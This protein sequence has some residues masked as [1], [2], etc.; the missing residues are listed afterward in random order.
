MP[1]LFQ[2]LIEQV[3]ERHV[4]YIANGIPNKFGMTC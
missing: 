2:H 3:Y 4:R 1:N